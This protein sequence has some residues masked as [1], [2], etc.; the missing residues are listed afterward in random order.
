MTETGAPSPDPK[1][2]AEAQQEPDPHHQAPQGPSQG[3]PGTS[4]TPPRLTPSHY[5]H[6]A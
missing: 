5:A 3:A 2:A 6:Y 1:P 4:S